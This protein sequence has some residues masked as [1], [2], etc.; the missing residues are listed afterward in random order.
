[1]AATIADTAAD[2]AQY[3]IIL[4][5]SML[6]PPFPAASPAARGQAFAAFFCILRRESPFMRLPCVNIQ[7]FVAIRRIFVL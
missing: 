1:M 4:R 7:T 2:A 3:R 5:V 6:T